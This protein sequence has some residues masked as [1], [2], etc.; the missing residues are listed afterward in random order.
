M[1]ESEEGRWRGDREADRGRQIEGG[2][3]SYNGISRFVHKIKTYIPH[4]SH[5]ILQMGTA[6]A[7]G[8]YLQ[9]GLEAVPCVVSCSVQV[10][11]E[12]AVEGKFMGVA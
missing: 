4:S 1:E 12:D 8:F 10:I 2:D 5:T 9:K 3:L 7:H 11:H 6:K